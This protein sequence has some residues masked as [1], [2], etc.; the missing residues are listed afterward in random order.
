MLHHALDIKM[1]AA[2]L[3]AITAA[4]TDAVAAPKGWEDVTLKGILIA[5]LVFVGRLYLGQ[6]KEHKEEIRL[7][8]EEIKATWAEHKN[9]VEKREIKMFDC[10]HTQNVT[11]AKLCDLTQEQTDHYRTFVKA[12]VDAKLNARP[13]AGSS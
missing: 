12:A 11:L 4:I 9:E 1:L 8:K 3:I 13:G 7:H 5:A 10:M 6:A 2:S